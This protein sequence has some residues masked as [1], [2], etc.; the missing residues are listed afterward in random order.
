MEHK[1]SLKIREI[2]TKEKK[3]T[4]YSQNTFSL[5]AKNIIIII[6]KE[7]AKIPKCWDSALLDIRIPT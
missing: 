6:V 2:Q 5:N 4:V 1:H 7:K 3:W